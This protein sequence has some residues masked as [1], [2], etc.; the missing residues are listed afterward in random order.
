MTITETKETRAVFVLCRNEIG[1]SFDTDTAEEL[2]EKLDTATDFTMG[3]DG[4]EY[5]FIETGDIDSIMEAEL[6][7]DHYLLGCCSAW[8]IADITGLTV[9]EVEKA[10]K[11]DSMAVLGA[12]MAKD[13]EAVQG[14]MASEDG[15]GHYFSGYDGNEYETKHWHVFRTN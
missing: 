10:Q 11:A 3:V 13:I 6:D 7:D 9:D 5:R 1:L 14:R 4:G 12:L 8:F 15:Y 2:C